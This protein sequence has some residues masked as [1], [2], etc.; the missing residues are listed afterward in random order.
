MKEA[1]QITVVF[2]IFSRWGAQDRAYT[3]HTECHVDEL[4]CDSLSCDF[5]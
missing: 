2:K 3:S 5:E 4:L 1:L